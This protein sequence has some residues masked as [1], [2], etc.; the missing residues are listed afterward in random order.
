[1]HDSTATPAFPVS[2]FHRWGCSQTATCCN[3]GPGR[4]FLGEGLEEER[5]A[6]GGHWFSS[7]RWLGAL[8]GDTAKP[9]LGTTQKAPETVGHSCSCLLAEQGVWVVVVQSLSHV[10]LF[11][12]P[13]LPLPGSPSLFPGVCSNSCPSSQ[14]CHPNI[15]SSVAPFSSCP[16]SFPAS[17]SFP[18]SWLFAS[19]GPSTGASALA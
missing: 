3:K 8:Q 12:T 17:G 13:R 14:W 1:M 4:W 2:T 11:V 19:G 6:P 5:M 18:M 15:S 7:F 9:W 10:R 16:Q